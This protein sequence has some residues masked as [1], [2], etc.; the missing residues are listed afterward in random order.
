M[1]SH[2]QCQNLSI[3]GRGPTQ[4]SDRFLLCSRSIVIANPSVST[5]EN[6]PGVLGRVPNYSRVTLGFTCGPSYTFT[7]YDKKDLARPSWKQL[8][9][10][11]RR[12]GI[13]CRSR[14]DN[15]SPEV[16]ARLD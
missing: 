13:P 16:V 1:V 10:R 7:Y 15:I 8:H 6:F 4:G 11:G 2:D 3:V 5:P 9:R 14:M 12:C